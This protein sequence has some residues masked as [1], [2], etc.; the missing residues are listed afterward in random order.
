MRLLYCNKSRLGCYYRKMWKKI[1]SKPLNILVADDHYANQL[2]TQSLLQRE[3]HNVVLANHGKDALAAASVQNFSIILL[4][5]QMPIMDG[6][7]AIAHI[8]KLPNQNANTLIFALTA[9]CSPSETQHLLKVGFNAVLP[10]PFRMAD[11]KKIIQQGRAN[12]A[13]FAPTSPIC[14]DQK[15]YQELL[16][17]PL[18]DTQTIDIL[19]DAIG[20]DRMMR[21]LNAYWK[22]ADKM[23]NTLLHTRLSNPDRFS[24]NLI[25]LRKTA[26]GLK[27]AS[28]NIGLFRASRL[29]AKLQ[30]APVETIPLLIE[31]IVEVLKISRIEIY[32]YCKLTDG[33]DPG[34]PKQSL[35]L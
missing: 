33:I 14:S 15:D 11:L 9:H 23:L 34:H 22:D 16:Q 12:P 20:P 32:R 35:A 19:Y 6:I 3:G 18:L 31:G 30:N 29:A 2:L 24:E 1:V 28:A 8:R 7:T 26:H 13:P 5:I 4:D 25:K 21:V 17:L 27:G 10:K